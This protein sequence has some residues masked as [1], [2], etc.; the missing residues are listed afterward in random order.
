MININY[1][2]RR[3]KIKQLFGNDF[4]QRYPLS[5]KIL[6]RYTRSRIHYGERETK[7]MALEYQHD[8]GL[9]GLIKSLTY[10]LLH[11]LN[12]SVFRRSNQEKILASYS[13]FIRFEIFAERM[14][15]KY[16]VF[17]VL[18]KKTVTHALKSGA[19]KTINTDKFSYNKNLQRLLSET[20]E[21][22]SKFIDSN[23]LDKGALFQ[24][25]D[26]LENILNQEITKL[27]K[28]FKDKKIKLYVT[29]FDQVYDDIFNILA[30]QKAG[31]RTKCIAHAFLPGGIEYEP[32]TNCLPVFA[33]KLY[34][35]S[36]E[37]YDLLK[38]YEEM[39]KIEIGGYPKY[40]K[41]YIEKKKKQYPEK[42]II[43]FFSGYRISEEWMKIEKP[44]RKRL[45]SLFKE[46][47]E[48][49]G[50]EI[51]IRYQNKEEPK[52]R[53][54]EKELLKKCHIKVSRNPFIKD[55]LQ[56]EITLAFDTSCLY[57]AKI[58]GKKA[59][60]LFT[61]TEYDKIFFMKNIEYIDVDDIKKKIE[62]K[63][64]L[65]V[66]YDLFLDLDSVINSS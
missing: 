12:L 42:K 65:D 48:K 63:T 1:F 21:F 32:K 38:G 52:I 50:Y 46:I 14:K 16:N 62:E 44:I 9:I 66:R 26:I 27:S 20:V 11:L 17:T 2:E 59:Y 33:D 51:Y 60:T 15:D 47:A 36:Q 18:N 43:T 55:I 56:S 23:G 28:I 6:D 22:I 24:K 64:N 53:E 30:C 19:R 7:N 29:A 5:S 37:D 13:I 34:V 8:K 3:D 41:E 54:H 49:Q 35:W 25:L 10:F 57:E 31:I 61:H 4:Y 45:F 40:T 58:L 39:E